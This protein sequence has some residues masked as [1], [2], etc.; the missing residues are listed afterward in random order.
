[1]RQARYSSDH[2]ARHQLHRG[3]IAVVEG[4]G[5]G[6]QDLKNA[7]RPPEMSQGRSQ[8]RAYAE[9]AAAGQIDAC[10]PFGVIAQHDFAGPYT[11]GGDA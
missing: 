5:S 6:G 4:I 7:Q 9:M 8:H 2:H 10:I 3:Y 11:F 1:M